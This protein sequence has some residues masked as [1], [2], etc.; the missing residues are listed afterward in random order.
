M[1]E[2]RKSV[3]ISHVATANVECKFDVLDSWDNDN[4]KIFG[5]LLSTTIPFVQ[6]RDDEL[7]DGPS[8]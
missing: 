7:D 2:E 1:D 4:S 6:G 8:V 5:V 3:S